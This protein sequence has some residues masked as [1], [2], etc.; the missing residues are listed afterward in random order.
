MLSLRRET[1]RST[2]RTLLQRLNLDILAV[3]VAVVGFVFL[4]YLLN[5]GLVNTQLNLLLL[6]P[7]TLLSIFFLAL[8]GILLFLR[9][10]PLLLRLGAWVTMRRR[11]A[12]PM[13]ALA[14]MARAPRQSVRT[15]LLLSLATACM[16]FLLIFM[17]SQSQRIADVAAYQ[18]GADISGTVR[19]NGFTS[20]DRPQLTAQYR[21]VP[22][23]LSASDWLCR[24]RRCRSGRCLSIAHTNECG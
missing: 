22:G 12:A 14:Q 4:E 8:A 2:Q 3:V 6:A 16:L 7:L 24:H 23:I 18:T 19:D 21:H 1:A 15:T 13:L 10:Y 5:T 9:L 17:A 20:I 11:S